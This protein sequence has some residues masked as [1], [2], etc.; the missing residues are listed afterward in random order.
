M[1]KHVSYLPDSC[2]TSINSE[3][4]EGSVKRYHCNRAGK[5]E[6]DYYKI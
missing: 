5:A 6:V 4:F 3:C 1:L 2:T